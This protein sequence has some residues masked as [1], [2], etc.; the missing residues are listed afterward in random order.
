M[1][2]NPSGR[3]SG[4]RPT[5]TADGVLLVGTG[6][7][8]R[9]AIAQD[10]ASLGGKVLRIDLDTGGP[11]PG[12]PYA[13]AQNPAQRLIWSYGHRN[14]QGIAV[15]PDT[16][17]A[18]SAEH[19]PTTDDEVNLLRAGANY[20]WDPSQGGTVG[21]YDESVPM[22]DLQRFPDAV[23]AAWSSGNPV[24][25]VSGAAFLSGSQWG[26]LDGV[27]AVGALRGEKLLL[28]RLGPGGGVAK[29]TVPAPLDGAFGRLRAVRVAPDGT[30][31]VSTSNGT[32]DRVLRI[33]PV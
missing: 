14:V 32:D 16:G 31:F 19:G 28:M 23:P 11:A 3:H 6:D 27:L 25:A 15:T 13:D 26:D 20:G 17:N 33:D 2:I 8:A 10:L 1:P 7:T 30:L 4:C 29:V 5:L 21:G 18:Y 22:T 24:E 9:G 12:N